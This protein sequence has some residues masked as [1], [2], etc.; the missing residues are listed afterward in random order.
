MAAASSHSA[1]QHAQLPLQA[2]EEAPL[3][4][5]FRES[6]AT[7]EPRLRARPLTLPQRRL[8]QPL[9]RGDRPPLVEL[10][11]SERERA[12]E[13]TRPLGVLPQRQRHLAERT[14]RLDLGTTVLE[15]L[16]S[17]LRRFV[18]R[19][20]LERPSHVLFRVA[21]TQQSRHHFAPVATLL[22]FEGLHVRPIEDLEVLGDLVERLRHA[23]RQLFRLHAALADGEIRAGAGTQRALI[24][25]GDGDEERAQRC[26]H[27]EIG[28]QLQRLVD[29]HRDRSG[30]GGGRGGGAAR[31]HNPYSFIFR[32]SVLRWMPRISAAAPICPL[33]CASTRAMWR[34]SSSASVSRAP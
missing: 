17:A 26:N 1:R 33:V 28:E 4:R 25:A 8:P 29:A 31:A 20:R 23:A 13:V 9:A 10:R 11:F 18:P 21:G 22:R 6:Q 15:D 27:L 32:V 12:L 3:A 30:R 16:G 5:R 34:A 19:P 14:E 24:G 7:R 2:A